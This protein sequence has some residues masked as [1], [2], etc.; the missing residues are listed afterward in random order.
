VI[1]ITADIVEGRRLIRN[2]DG[3]VTLT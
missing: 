1:R 3:T 2:G